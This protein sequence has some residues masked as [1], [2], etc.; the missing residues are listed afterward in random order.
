MPELDDLDALLGRLTDRLR[1]LEARV[2]ELEAQQVPGADPAFATVRAGNLTAGRVVLA[3]A[4][5]LLT[6]DADLAF[7]GSQLALASQGSGG[8]VLIGGDVQLYRGAADRMVTPDDLQVQALLRLGTS[9]TTNQTGERFTLADDATKDLPIGTKPYSVIFIRDGTGGNLAIVATLGGRNTSAI[10]YDQDNVWRN[11]DTDT[12]H[13]I[14]RLNDG[15]G[16]RYVIKNRRG[17]S[18][19]YDAQYFSIG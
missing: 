19:T 6:D 5:G 18:R 3:G 13:N 7:N 10:I 2:V 15:G 16:D 17:G 12:F 1:A 9:L 4:G 14:F 11:A 8:G